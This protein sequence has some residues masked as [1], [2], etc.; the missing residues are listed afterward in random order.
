MKEDLVLVIYTDI[1]RVII[2]RDAKNHEVGLERKV[3]Y[4]DKT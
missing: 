2:H 4:C 3:R 1:I